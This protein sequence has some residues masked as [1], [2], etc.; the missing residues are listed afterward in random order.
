MPYGAA[1]NTVKSVYQPPWD[2]AAYKN[3]PLFHCSSISWW[4]DLRQCTRKGNNTDLAM[5]FLKLTVLVF[6]K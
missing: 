3:L 4:Q 2:P 1:A 5:Q 6:K